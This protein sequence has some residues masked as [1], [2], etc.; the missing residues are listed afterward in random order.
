MI[1]YGRQSIS[2]KDIKK[3]INVLKSDFITQGPVL[4]KFEAS[5]ASKVGVKYAVAS[6][7]ATSSLLISCLALGLSEND[8]LWTSPN[9][10]VASANCALHCKAKI[11]FVDIDP[12]T[13]NISL[14]KLKEKLI[15]AKKNN[16]LP[17]IIIPVHYSGQ[18]TDQKEIRKLSIRYGFKIIED[19]S[20]SLG[21]N[22]SKEKVGSCKWS[23]ITV[24][25]FHP[26]K[27]ITTCEGGIS[28]TNSKKLKDKMLMFRTHGITKNQN[29]MVNKNESKNLWYYEQQLLG[30]NFRLS[31][32]HAALGLS[33]LDDLEKFVKKRNEIAKRY[34]KKLQSTSLE[35]P[36]IK[37]HN[38]SSFHLYVI[39]TKNKIERKKVFKYLRNKNIGV[40]VH[41]IHIHL[42]PYYKKLGFKKGDYPVC[43]NF[44]SRIIS[45]PIYPNLSK[46]EQDFV[47]NSLKKALN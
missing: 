11:D 39:K 44:C 15:N 34:N 27:I 47:I 9:S 41:Y 10:F 37:N 22:Y 1:P 26:V 5:L 30:F 20:H 2:R 24:F 16:I 28:T 31:D 7:S 12:D 38:Y 18:P 36:V 35:L 45:I 43:E 6:N 13:G 8:L 40:N 21:A 17:K 33:Q 32:V 29:E 3:V 19:A 46:K 14:D 25:S 42:H 23:D 4:D